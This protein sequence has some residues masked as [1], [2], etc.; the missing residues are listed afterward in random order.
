MIL[1]LYILGMAIAIAAGTCLGILAGEKT[2]KW[3]EKKNN[4]I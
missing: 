3:L 4:N 2:D 1:V